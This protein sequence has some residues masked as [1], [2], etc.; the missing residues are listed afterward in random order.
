MH[1]GWEG[2]FKNIFDPPIWQPAEATLKYGPVSIFQ[3][4]TN[5]NL[6]LA[7]PYSGPVTKSTC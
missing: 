2:P 1:T 4:K 7:I 5:W 3:S 6:K